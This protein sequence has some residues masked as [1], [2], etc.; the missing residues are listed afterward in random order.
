MRFVTYMG[1]FSVFLSIFMNIVLYMKYPFSIHVI[2]ITMFHIAMIH[3]NNPAQ[4]G[5]AQLIGLHIACAMHG[6]GIIPSLNE[7]PLRKRRGINLNIES[8]LI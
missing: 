7:A 6:I 1:L 4:L 5:V 2:I 8:Q 3:Y